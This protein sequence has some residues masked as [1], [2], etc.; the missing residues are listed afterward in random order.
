MM[1]P[2]VTSGRVSRNPVNA[3]VGHTDSEPILEL[4]NA[5]LLRGGAAVLHNVTLTMRPHEH[6]AIVGPN[7]AGKSS[8]IRLLTLQDYPLS[9]S[10]GEPPLRL[11]GRERWDIVGLRAR[12]GSVSTDPPNSCTGGVRALD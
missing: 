11:F 10:T 12:I 7:G 9:N 1:R 6:T 8:L 5:T 3:E 2:R 4:R